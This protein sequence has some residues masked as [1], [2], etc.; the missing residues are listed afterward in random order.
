MIEVKAK[1]KYSKELGHGIRM[2]IDV[3]L[4]DTSKDPNNKSQQDINFHRKISR[5]D[6]KPS[7]LAFSL[8]KSQVLRRTT[9]RT[10]PFV[11]LLAAFP[12]R[13]LSP[14]P[15]GCHHLDLDINICF[16]AVVNYF[17]RLYPTTQP[18]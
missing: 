16:L 18:I 4:F 15:K 5:I 17:I 11:L 14:S 7:S 12:L 9:Q 8:P 3:S 13:T 1:N 6:S 10:Q 2:R